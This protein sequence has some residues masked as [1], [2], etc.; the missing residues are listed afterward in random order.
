MRKYKKLL[1]RI[2]LSAVLLVLLLYLSAC[3]FLPFVLNLK[4]SQNI[5]CNY[6][7]NRF[8]GKINLYDFSISSKFNLDYIISI[9]KVNFSRKDKNYLTIDDCKLKFSVFN[10]KDNFISANKIYLKK[11]NLSATKK[12]KNK[13]RFNLS[14]IPDLKINEL[15]IDTGAFDDITSNFTFKNLD[16]SNYNFKR[17]LTF[18]L[19]YNSKYFSS[20]VIIKRDSKFYLLKNKI[21]AQNLKIYF[22]DKYC[23]IEG[24]IFDFEEGPNFIIKGRNLP[25]YEIER[26]FLSIF[27]HFKKKKNFI[28]NFKDFNG[29]LD[30]DLIVKQNNINGLV[31]LRNLAATTVPLNVPIKFKK[32][33][34]NFYDNKI[35]LNET[36]ILGNKPV[37]TTLEI[38]S[39]FSDDLK[40]SGT[41]DSVIDN[42]FAKVYFRDVY[43]LGNINLSVKYKIKSPVIDVIYAVTPAYMSDISY[44][45]ARLGLVR[46]KRTVNA[47]TRKINDELSLEN[48]YYTA[49]IN[50]KTVEII[51][52]SGTFNKINGKYK[53]TQISGET[54]E[55]APVALLG[56]LEDRL[57]GGVFSGDLDYDFINKK[58]FGNLSLN[59]TRFKGFSVKSALISADNNNLKVKAEGKYN[60]EPFSADLVLLNSFSPDIHIFNLDLYLR[61]YVFSAIEPKRQKRHFFIPDKPKNLCVN[62]DKILIRL[63]EANKDKISVKNINLEGSVKNNIIYFN[64]DNA[65]FAQGRLF[66]DGKYDYNNHNINANFSAADIDSNSAGYQLFNLKDYFKGKMSAKLGVNIQNKFKTLNGK[67]EFEIKD[68]ELTKIG[69][70]EFVLRRSKKKH[71]YVFSLSDVIKLDDRLIKDKTSNIKGR[72]D[73][74]NKL[75]KNANIYISNDLIALFIEGNYDI[76]KEYTSLKMWGKYD[77]KTEGMISV[78]KIPLSFITKFLFD[79]KELTAQYSEKIL[80]IPSI[81]IKNNNIKTFSIGLKGYVNNPETFELELNR[82]KTR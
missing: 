18:D 73:L 14:Y 5:I 48:Y 47:K 67:G 35:Y 70:T 29:D 30:I 37:S 45:G 42:D 79:A 76:E 38:I 59:N 80:K 6:L 8:Q 64:I 20:P 2:L 78:F 15:I 23:L 82:I 31:K 81:K 75:V 77:K 74:N 11:T 9:N 34:F 33:D 68:G 71:P 51:K 46:A 36:G 17:L 43:I 60:N 25:V 1:Y 72:F 69:S 44:K 65:V 21:Y 49:V 10:V 61:K 50:G 62:A 22:K 12:K 41:V 16:L 24:K 39:A 3:L 26:S 27:K 7:E 55:N 57:K 32:A 19:I 13:F 52:G 58:L 56:F 4:L 54:K 63:E 53:L 66:A 28:E 40:V